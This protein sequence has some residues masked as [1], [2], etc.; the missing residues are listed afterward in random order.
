MNETFANGMSQKDHILLSV[1]PLTP[2]FLMLSKLFAPDLTVR[3][4][5]SPIAPYLILWTNIILFRTGRLRLHSGN[6]V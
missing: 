6:T 1:F 4:G 3:Q 5:P 2:L